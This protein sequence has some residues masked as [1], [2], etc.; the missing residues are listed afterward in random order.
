MWEGWLE[1]EPRNGA[2]AAGGGVVVSAVESRQPEREHLQYWA[3][4]LSDVYV[5]GSLDRALHPVTVR[6][7]VAES[8]ASDAPARRIVTRPVARGPEPVLDPFEIGERSLDIL[9]Q[10]LRALDRPRLLNIIAAF[11]LNATGEDLTGMTD[12]QL[13]TFITVAVEAQL[14]L[15]SK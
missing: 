1:F 7:R 4:G 2:V 12:A 13:V 3:D 11:D 6:T 14:A 8:P 15:R 9:A 10:E 5:E